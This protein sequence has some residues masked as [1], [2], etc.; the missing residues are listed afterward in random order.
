MN[1]LPCV[2]FKIQRGS[3]VEIDRRKIIKAFI[4]HPSRAVEH[5]KCVSQQFNNHTRVISFTKDFEV[6]QLIDSVI[7]IEDETF[8]LEEVIDFN[9]FKTVS[10]RVL[11]LPHGYSR[12]KLS[13]FFNGLGK[14][15]IDCSEE[16]FQ[17]EEL[18]NVYFGTGNFKMKIR[19]DTEIVKNPLASGI[20]SI[21]KVKMLVTRFGEK[22]TCLRCKK[23]GH[24][25]R[26][27][28]LNKLFCSNCNKTGHTVNECNMARRT[29]K[30]LEEHPD[31]FDQEMEVKE[32]EAVH[33]KTRNKRAFDETSP[34]YDPSSASTK[35]AK[36]ENN[37]DNE[38]ESD[39]ETESKEPESESDDQEEN[40]EVVK[41]QQ[42]VEDEKFKQRNN[43][44]LNDNKHP[45]KLN[46]KV[47]SNQNVKTVNSV[48]SKSINQIP[49]NQRRQSTNQ[50]VSY[51]KLYVSIEIC[52]LQETHFNSK[53]EVEYFEKILN[54]YLV[55]CPLSETKSR[56]VGILVKSILNLG[57]ISN[58]QF[59]ENRIVNLDLKINGN[60]F[61]FVNIYAPNLK[62]EQSR[63]IE[64]L[65]R[66]NKIGLDKRW[67][68][69]I[70]TFDLVE[71][72]FNNTDSER[73][74]FTW[75]NGSQYSRI[76]R[77]YF[78]TNKQ[79]NLNYCN[80]F[81][82]SM[83]D[84]KIII[85]KLNFTN[86]STLKGSFKKSNEWKLNERVLEDKK[87]ESRRLFIERKSFINGLFDSLNNLDFNENEKRDEIKSKI[88]NYYKEERLGIEKRACETKRN[89]I[90]Q[91]TKN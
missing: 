69:L 68:D 70:K 37:R 72:V 25:R 71:S 18:E 31:E 51:T 88:E 82:T 48:Q 3:N 9:R 46:S 44:K 78:R 52:F 53:Q 8:K 86:V 91:P 49:I 62:D 73:L 58:F 6:N 60:I 41:I 47:T 87:R 28:D 79:I 80:F 7:V 45:K 90:F 5:I 75:T 76:D 4:Q 89:F 40:I 12:N 67:S 2:C 63:F 24:I 42:E 32:N 1:K 61:S 27:C 34:L 64:E 30:E 54:K 55:Y 11:W 81:T 50:Y 57:E 19:Y 59:Y 35:Q 22:P 23:V 10:Y 14:T 38:T 26:N 56:G 74:K 29:E 43:Q 84:H 39:S 85:S 20:Y 33:Q 66:V 77:L 17:V 83:S 16:M 65:Y 13:Q 15:I 36:N 21:D